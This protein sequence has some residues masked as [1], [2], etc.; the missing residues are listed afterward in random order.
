MSSLGGPLNWATSEARGAKAS[1]PPPQPQYLGLSPGDWCMRPVKNASGWDYKV[2]RTFC[3]S[4][5]N[6]VSVFVTIL[7]CSILSSFVLDIFF[8][9]AQQSISQQQQPPSIHSPTRNDRQGVVGVFSGALVLPLVRC[10]G[11]Y[12]LAGSLSC[13]ELRIHSKQGLADWLTVVGWLSAYL[14]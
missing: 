10:G 7:Q 4:G 14:T 9:R 11:L 3:R 5:A 6:G 1:R 8:F 13:D 12:L 2:V